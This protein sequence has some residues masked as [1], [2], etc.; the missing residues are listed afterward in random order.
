MNK[1]I[2]D[3]LKELIYSNYGIHFSDEKNYLFESKIERILNREKI[4]SLEEFYNKI[5]SQNQESLDILV[6]YVTTTHTF[7]FREKEHLDVLG[8]L[9]K[10]NK[11]GIP[12]IWCAASSTGEEVY[13]IIITLLENNINDFLIIASDIN[14]DVLNFMNKGVYSTNRLYETSEYIKNKY[15]IRLNEDKYQISKDL[16]TYFKIKKLNIIEENIFEQKFDIIFCRNVL[17]Y[18]DK[19]T[20][21]KAISNLLVN[22]SVGGHL[23]IGLTETLINNKE[24]IKK[25]YSSVYKKLGD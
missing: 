3:K 13:S 24:D 11:I 15:F 19:E 25:I 14:K 7:F 4:G 21:N 17:I 2:I 5:K 1:D 9:I 8:E 10:R 23:F 16:R 6:N 12:K 22:L 20:R 18:F